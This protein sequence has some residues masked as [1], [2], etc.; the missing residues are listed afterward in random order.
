MKY[1]G[2]HAS[3]LSVAQAATL[4]GMLT[5]PGGYNPLD[6]PQASKQRRNTVLQLMVE[7]NKLSASE[8][9]NY[10][11]TAMVTDDQ[12]HYQSGYKYPYYFDAVINEAIKKYGLSET[13]IMNGG[14]KIYT[15]LNQ[16]YQKQLQ[17]DYTNSELF[18]YNAAD[19]TQAPVSYTHLTLPTKA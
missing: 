18:P 9:K 3:Q 15:A 5:D 13:E 7:N 6:H 1:F 10:Q 12:Y 2:V 14:Y 16:N 8:A 4:A 19:G 17:A 11:Q